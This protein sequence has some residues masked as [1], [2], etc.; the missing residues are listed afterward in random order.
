M[1][2]P[3]KPTNVASS[4]KAVSLLCVPSKLY[5]CLIYNCIQPIAESVLP[6]KQKGFHPCRSSYD[7][8]VS[9][10]EDI[11]Y[12]FDKK[13]KAGVVFV[14]LSAAYDTVW[15]RGLTLKLLRILPSKEM[16][17]VIMSMIS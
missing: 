4:H 7:Q 3:K 1:L 15:L 5:E 2:K 13:L 9:L 6:K 12:A 10:T 17:H 8:V 11:E 16:A 14:D